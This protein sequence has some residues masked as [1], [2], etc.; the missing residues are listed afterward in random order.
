MRVGIAVKS[1]QAVL[2]VFARVHNDA[3]TVHIG[4][5][6][7]RLLLAV[8]CDSRCLAYIG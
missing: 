4:G 1:I 2:T 5:D 7:V 6:P 3:A 8:D